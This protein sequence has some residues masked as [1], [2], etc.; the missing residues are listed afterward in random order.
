MCGHFIRSC[1]A[2]AILWML[3]SSIVIAD[4][5]DSFDDLSYCQD[6]NN[7]GLFD[8]NRWDI[9][10]PHWTLYDLIGDV[11]TEDAN[12]GWLRLTTATA[13]LPFTFYGALV[14]DGDPDPNTS[15]TYY[16]NKVPHYILTKVKFNDVNKGGFMT[17]IHAN[18]M[19]WE[20]YALDVECDDNYFSIDWLSGINFKTAASTTKVVDRAG[21]FWAVIQFDPTHPNGTGDP[22]DPNHHYLRAAFWDGDKFDWNGTWDMQVGIIS[23][24]LD[25]NRWTYWTSGVSG[26]AAYGSQDTNG[27]PNADIS[28]DSIEIRRGYWS[29]VS[30]TLKLTVVHPNYGTVNV[31]PNLVDPNDTTIQRYTNGTQIVLT[32]TPIGGK[33]FRAWT[34]WDDPNRY[35]DANFAVDDANTVLY[36]TMNRDY[37]VEADF[38]CG[39]G[40]APLLG[41]GLLALSLAV[42]IRRCS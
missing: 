25:P 15:T 29:N 26:V 10:N 20:T 35:P 39:S 30:H 11:F 1:V 40:L 34:I 41:V 28:F 6:P 24:K 27:N 42:V 31:D 13:W 16:D 14:D 5:Y 23:S 4:T 33:L 8:P 32:A 12:S 38:K 3:A 7:P 9:D 22:N 37:A 18:P 19:T 2:V 21:G 17:L 36:L